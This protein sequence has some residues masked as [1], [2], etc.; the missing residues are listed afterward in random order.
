M[1]PLGGWFRIVTVVGFKKLKLML[2]QN[3]KKCDD[4]CIKLYTCTLLSIMRT[5]FCISVISTTDRKLN[6][7]YLSLYTM[8]LQSN[9]DVNCLNH[10]IH[11]A[12]K[13]V[14]RP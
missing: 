2:Q 5:P 10:I 11:N 9:V 6:V 7:I 12:E 1:L 14:T 13:L 3:V 4:M 8:I